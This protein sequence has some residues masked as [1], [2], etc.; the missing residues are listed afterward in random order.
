M[1]KPTLEAAQKA[2]T[3]WADNEELDWVNSPKQAVY[4]ACEEI[5]TT[6]DAD[7]DEVLNFLLTRGMAL[8]DNQEWLTDV[9]EMLRRIGRDA[10]PS[11]V[12]TPNSK[13][14]RSLL[15]KE[16]WAFD[17]LAEHE[18]KELVRDGY[19]DDGSVIG[20]VVAD[21][22]QHTVTKF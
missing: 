10:E 2:S 1:D 9:V 7:Y 12:T 3:L 13:A 18:P 14:S 8:E 4:M 6:N 22:D 11:M 15:S 21:P 17:A 20:K 16:T 5:K 19:E